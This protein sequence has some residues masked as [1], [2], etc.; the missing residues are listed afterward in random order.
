M[1][2]E[3]VMEWPG[4]WPGNEVT[5]LK[6]VKSTFSFCSRTENNVMFWFCLCSLKN[7]SSFVVFGSRSNNNMT[8]CVE[9]SPCHK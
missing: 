2:G 7:S 1:Q 6:T 8:P 3:D 9:V 4:I 5:K